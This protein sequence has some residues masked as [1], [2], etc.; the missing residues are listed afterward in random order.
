MARPRRDLEQPATG[1]DPAREFQAL[2]LYLRANDGGPAAVINRRIREEAEAIVARRLPPDER[3]DQLWAFVDALGQRVG[4]ERH[5]AQLLNGPGPVVD[6]PNP[7]T[8]E[9]S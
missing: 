6:R 9:S 2:R 4:A 5:V 3:L 1:R 8:E 7:L